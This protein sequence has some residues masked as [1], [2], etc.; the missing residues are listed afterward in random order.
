M[1]F[2]RRFF[3]FMA[4][5]S[6]GDNSD[7]MGGWDSPNKWFNKYL[8]KLVNSSTAQTLPKNQQLKKSET[9]IQS[10]LIA[11]TYTRTSIS[12]KFTR[13]INTFTPPRQTNEMN[14][15]KEEINKPRSTV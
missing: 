9:N 11:N 1:K 7:C 6:L 2:S 4:D 14:A 5:R 13:H 15:S 8:A 10:P 3:E 12:D